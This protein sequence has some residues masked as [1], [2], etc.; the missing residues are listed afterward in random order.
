MDGNLKEL[1]SRWLLDL[2][3]AE[4]SDR[5]A[6]AREVVTDD[7]AI[8]QSGQPDGDGGPARLVS[9]VEAGSAPF[10]DV[11]LEIAVGPLVDGHLVAARWVFRGS[12]RGGIPGSVAAEGT[13]V[14]VEGMDLLRAQDGRFAE[15]WSSSDWLDLM[16]QLGVR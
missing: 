12:Y 5:E 3:H 10:S 6:I 7:F 8:H 16:R 1:Y 11:R 15:Y 4:P 13:E 2:W 9:L 14:T